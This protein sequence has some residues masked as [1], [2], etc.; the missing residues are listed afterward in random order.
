MQSYG[1]D[2]LVRVI[3]LLGEET[4]LSALRE[5]YG[6]AGIATCYFYTVCRSNDSTRNAYYRIVV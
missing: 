1:P 2:L 5:M 6:S 3:N 4:E